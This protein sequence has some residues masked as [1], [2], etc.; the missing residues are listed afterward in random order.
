MSTESKRHTAEQQ[1]DHYKRQRDHARRKAAAANIALLEERLANWSIRW[2]K[3]RAEERMADTTAVADARVETAR[4]KASLT[5]MEVTQAAHASTLQAL[6]YQTA[7]MRLKE[8]AL[9]LKAE[10]R[11]TYIHADEIIKIIDE[12][13]TEPAQGGTI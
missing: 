7:L 3:Q 9:K 8:R 13:E 6:R 5:V 2:E 4:A 10:D 1:A 12:C 11:L